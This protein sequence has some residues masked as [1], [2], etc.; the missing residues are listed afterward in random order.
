MQPFDVVTFANVVTFFANTGVLRD[1]YVALPTRTAPRGLLKADVETIPW[2]VVTLLTNAVAV[3][4]LVQASVSTTPDTSLRFAIVVA[5]FLLLTIG[6]LAN[7]LDPNTSY[8][9]RRSA[10]RVSRG[11]GSGTGP[12]LLAVLAL[13]AV[14]GLGALLTLTRF[15]TIPQDVAFNQTTAPAFF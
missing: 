1:G 11:I 9:G 10:T 14:C 4:F 7:L 5:T 13:A 12:I 3:G 6:F 15:Q 2:Y 8:I